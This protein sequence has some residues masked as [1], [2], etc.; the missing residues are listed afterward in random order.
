MN[1][2]LMIE[3]QTEHVAFYYYSGHVSKISIRIA[4]S[5]DAYS[6]ILFDEECWL[7]VDGVPEAESLL[8]LQQ[9]REALENFMD[10][11]GVSYRLAYPIEI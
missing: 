6:K 4:E 9:L 8:T 5:S 1:Y 3:L 10:S 7:V 11:I 2:C